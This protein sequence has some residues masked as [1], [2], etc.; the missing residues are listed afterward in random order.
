MDIDLLNR[1]STHFVLWAPGQTAP[2]LVIGTL[3]F[4]APPFLTGRK[5]LPLKAVG[6]VHGLWELAP[7]DAGLTDGNVYHFWFEVDDT[8]PGHTAGARVSVTDPTAFTVDWR[9]TEGDGTQP[10]SVIK[11]DSGQLVPCD[12]DGTVVT[13]PAPGDSGKAGSKQFHNHLRVAGRVDA[14][15]ARRR[16]GAGC[17][18]VSRYYRHAR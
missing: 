3:Q 10:A 9:I 15:T 7:A 1:K 16:L 12:P 2:K 5:S 8:K 18:N 6:G 14:P 4:G 17:R 11:F 13:P